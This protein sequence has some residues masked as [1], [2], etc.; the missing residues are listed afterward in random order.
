[1]SRDSVV[2]ESDWPAFFFQI[3]IVFWDK[4]RPLLTES[5]V[6]VYLELCRRVPFD[7]SREQSTEQSLSALCKKLGKGRATVTEALKKFE[8]L[9]LIRRE[10]DRREGQR[11]LPQRIVLLGAQLFPQSEGSVSVSSEPDGSEPVSSHTAPH[12]EILL[13]QEIPS[14]KKDRKNTAAASPRLRVVKSSVPAPKTSPPKFD[15]DTKARLAH[16]IGEAIYGKTSGLTPGDWGRI[17]KLLRDELPATATVE[18]VA[19]VGAYLRQ[20][21]ARRK[22]SGDTPIA[23]VVESIGRHW[24]V[25]LQVAAPLGLPLPG[26]SQIS[27]EER[28]R[29]IEELRRRQEEQRQ[30][31]LKRALKKQAPY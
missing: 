10:T 20:V 26:E 28:Q 9:G 14:E 13:V 3:P 31:A 23:W 22:E 27:E 16:A 25:A 11:L 7:K 29:N 5:Q 4:Y 1:M 19:A 6:I 8:E 21:N 24:T 17:H 30:A 2:V 12:E 18:Q 15:G